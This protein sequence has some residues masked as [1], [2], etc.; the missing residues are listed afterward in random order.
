MVETKN[1]CI[2]LVRKALEKM[3]IWNVVSEMDLK[4]TVCRMGGGSNW[5]RIMSNSA[6]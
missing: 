5:L 3:L 6:F 2:I 1:T 4:E